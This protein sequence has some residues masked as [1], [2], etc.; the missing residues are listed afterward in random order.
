MR[1]FLCAFGNFFLAIPM[2]SVSSL[3]LHAGEGQSS[4]IVYNQ[5]NRNIYVSLPYLF[6]LPLEHTRYDIVLKNPDNEDD[7]TVENKV[8]LLSTAVECET[9]ISDDEIFPIPKIFNG[10]RFSVLFSGIQCAN[11]PILL[12]SPERL[13]RC[14]QEEKL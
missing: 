1:V 5:I 2:Q 11:R 7:D 13:I 3:S 10:T 12:L 6:N 14:A 4:A 9:E 8:I